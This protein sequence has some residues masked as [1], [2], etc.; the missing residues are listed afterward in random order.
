MPTIR[1]FLHITHLSEL[2]EFCL[3]AQS[4]HF[5]GID[6][7]FIRTRT[8]W[9]I[10]CLIQLSCPLPQTSL[11][12][13]IDVLRLENLEP[14]RI[15]LSR[16]PVSILHA[17][18]QDM[19]IIELLVGERPQQVFDTQLAAAFCGLGHQCSYSG[20]V[21]KLLDIEVDK[22]YRCSDWE[23]RPLSAEQI[24]YA[25]ED[26]NHLPSLY[27][28]LDAKLTEWRRKE[29]MEEEMRHQLKQWQIDSDPANAAKR[30]KPP[31]NWGPV[32]LENAHKLA[33]WREETAQRKN[34]PR[35]WI[36]SNQDLF[37]L[38]LHPDQAEGCKYPGKKP[39]GNLPPLDPIHQ[40]G[41]N[42]DTRY[43]NNG[44]RISKEQ[45]M[46]L[47][48]RFKK[49]IRAEIDILHRYA[50]EDHIAPELIAT[51]EDMKNLLLDQPSRLSS[52]W[53]LAWVQRHHP[54]LLESKGRFGEFSAAL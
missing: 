3:Q 26:V 33:Q 23:K 41:E 42:N 10:P 8:Y 48:Q 37:T 1:D 6:C 54:S 5:I 30:L 45:Q 24:T 17:A 47:R 38:A 51:R 28:L 4:A 31:P 11:T 13:V 49:T 50:N 12:A 2:E 18:E 39:P 21:E 44:E 35:Q 32:A 20:L 43:G 15:L 40:T 9:P 52:G 46:S 34:L 7:E 14:L 16:I 25:A 19:H 29:W 36:L 22:Q 27:Q 53:R